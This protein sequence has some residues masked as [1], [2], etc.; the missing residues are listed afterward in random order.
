MQMDDVESS[1]GFLKVRWTWKASET[2]KM[3][4]GEYKYSSPMKQQWGDLS[5][6]PNWQIQETDMAGFCQN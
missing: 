1:Q 5:T 4:N 2:P 6:K 3:G